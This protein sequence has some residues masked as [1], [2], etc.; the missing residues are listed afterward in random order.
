APR[1]AVH[2]MWP[3]RATESL[4]RGVRDTEHLRRYLTQM[5][6][7]QGYQDLSGQIISSVITLVIE[8][9]RVLGKLVALA[10]GEDTLRVTVA[11]AAG[12]SGRRA[13]PRPHAG[14]ETRTDPAAAGATGRLRAAGSGR[15]ARRSG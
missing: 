2:T 5:L 4:E 15:D 13:S 7:A 1:L 11:G 12:A 10:S 9:E 8:L 3:D 14:V 6:L